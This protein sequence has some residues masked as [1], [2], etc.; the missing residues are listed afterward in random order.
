[1]TLDINHTSVG[2]WTKFPLRFNFAHATGVMLL[3]NL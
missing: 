2:I 3:G 1:M